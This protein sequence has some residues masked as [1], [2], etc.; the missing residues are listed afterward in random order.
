MVRASGSRTENSNFW[1]KH[2]ASSG[3]SNDGKERSRDRNG[4]S[5]ST[6]ACTGRLSRLRRHVGR[7][8][9]SEI[10]WG[11]A[12]LRGRGMGKIPANIWPMDGDGFR[13]L[14]GRRTVDGL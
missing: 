4:S 10:H 7:P 5:C 2:L 8:A 13:L 9:G 14:V 12:V 6:R 1:T 3:L 11:K